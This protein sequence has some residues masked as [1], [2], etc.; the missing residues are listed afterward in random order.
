MHIK[1]L[2]NIGFFHT[3]TADTEPSLIDFSFSD[4]S[5]LLIMNCESLQMIR[6]HKDIFK[7][8]KFLTCF[9][10]YCDKFQQYNE[11]VERNQ[12]VGKMGDKIATHLSKKNIQRIEREIHS[13]YSEALKAK[14]KDEQCWACLVKRFRLDWG[15]FEQKQLQNVY[16][17]LKDTFTKLEEKI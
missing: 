3:H 1:N 6:I 4:F 9:F 10:L 17:T 7:S 15:Y 5:E 13:L 12:A 16:E 8:Q 14:A 11:L 2:Q